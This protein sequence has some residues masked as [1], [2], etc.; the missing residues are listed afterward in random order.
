MLRFASKRRSGRYKVSRFYC[1]SFQRRVVAV[2]SQITLR[3]SFVSFIFLLFFNAVFRFFW[4]L[5]FF[6]S[7]ALS[8]SRMLFLTCVSKRLLESNESKA[9]LHSLFPHWLCLQVY[10]L[11][12]PRLQQCVFIVV[13]ADD[14]EV[15]ADDGDAASV[16]VHHFLLLIFVLLSGH[17]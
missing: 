8:A 12:E 1:Y 2:T 4:I 15:V 6:S 7:Y 14:V 5:L 11:G 10:V 3:L 16:L 13:L 9:D 17:S